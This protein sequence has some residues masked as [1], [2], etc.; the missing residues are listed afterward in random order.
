MAGETV[1]SLALCLRVVPWSRTSH[2]VS[3]LTPFGVVSTVVK[4]A[5]RPKSAF[6]GQYDLN[7]T[8]EIVYYARAKGELHALRECAPLTTREALR[9]NFRALLL[10]EHFRA[11]AFDLAPH[12]PDARAWFDLLASALDRI[13]SPGARLPAELLS[14]EIDVLRLAGLDPAVESDAGSFV[15]RGARKIPI[16]AALA[17]CL[18]NPHMVK[19]TPILPDALRVIGLLFAFHLDRESAARRTVLKLISTTKESE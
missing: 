1:K 16:S 6:L 9:A 12:G 14:Y 7:Y 15:L 17:R 13:S 8:C 3:W 19:Y 2:I 18:K 11:L 4:G 5:V 10:A